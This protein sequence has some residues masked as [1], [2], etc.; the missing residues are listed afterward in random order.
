MGVG[1]NLFLG[2]VK[3]SFIYRLL[4]LEGTGGRGLGMSPV[5]FRELVPVVEDFSSRG[6]RSRAQYVVRVRNLLIVVFLRV[7]IKNSLLLRF[8]K[9]IH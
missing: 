3:R 1:D 5:E 4:V 7:F 6:L 9:R 8:E 2:D